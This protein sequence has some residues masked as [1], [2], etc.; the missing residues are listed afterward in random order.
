MY[1][2]ICERTVCFDLGSN[3]IGSIW[4]VYLRVGGAIRGGKHAFEERLTYLRGCL[5]AREIY[6]WRNTAI[7]LKSLGESNW[8]SN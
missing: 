4:G 1:N 8:C 7:L 6:R 2:N 3:P 5:C